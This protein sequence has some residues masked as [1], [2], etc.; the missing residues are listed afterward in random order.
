M[1]FLLLTNIALD[2]CFFLCAARAEMSNIKMFAALRALTE[3]FG[4][5]GGQVIGL[6]VY[7]YFLTSNF[8]PVVYFYFLTNFSKISFLFF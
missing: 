6:E 7:F 3:M 4:L 5:K 2:T 8:W 1:I